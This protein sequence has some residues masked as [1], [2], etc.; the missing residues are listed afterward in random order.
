[1][2][3]VT[4]EGMEG[5]GKSTQART[6]AELLGPDTVLTC[7][8][9]G[10]P[11]GREIRALLLDH[12]W[13]VADPTEVL[14][15]FADRA[16]HVFEVLRPA[17]AAGRS[18]V[19]DRYVDSSLAYQAYGRGLPL[20]ALAHVAAL[21]TGGLR[22]DLTLFFEVPIDVGLARIGARG[23]RD[24]IE[25]EARAFHERA[26]AGYDALMALDRDRWVIVDGMGTPDEVGERA[27]RVLRDRGLA[28]P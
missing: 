10:T 15:Y 18:V 17:L 12:R 24:R 23:P 6:L 9:G 13:T 22:P 26:R 28:R 14:L 5:C 8:P 2:A 25:V 20:E 4:L 27:V 11:L 7:E 16:Q 21:A 3:F 1:M 19:S